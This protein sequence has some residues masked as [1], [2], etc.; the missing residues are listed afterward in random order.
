MISGSDPETG[1][2][3]AIYDGTCIKTETNWCKCAADDVRQPLII[4]GDSVRILEK[5]F[6]EEEIQRLKTLNA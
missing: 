1:T 6:S 4:D 2:V 3:N 5:E